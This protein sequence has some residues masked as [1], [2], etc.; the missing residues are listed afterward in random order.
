MTKSGRLDA[1]ALR[2]EV[3]G[4]YRD[5]VKGFIKISDPLVAEKVD[6]ALASGNLWP[7]PWVQI[8]P[9]YKL[10]ANTDELIDRGLFDADARPSFSSSDGAP[11]QFYTHQVEAFERA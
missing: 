7:E 6:E 2:E 8:N 1:F 10:E 5:Y 9:T 11:W 4:T 3:I